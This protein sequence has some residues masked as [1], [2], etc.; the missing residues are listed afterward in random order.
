MSAVRTLAS[1]TAWQVKQNEL[2]QRLRSLKSSQKQ[3]SSRAEALSVSL[4]ETLAQLKASPTLLVPSYQ[5]KRGATHSAQPRLRLAEMSTYLEHSELA[6]ET[7]V[8][9]TSNRSSRGDREPHH[10]TPSMPSSPSPAILP[11]PA[12]RPTLPAAQPV[13]DASFELA[14]CADTP[15][16]S[17]SPR[18]LAAQHVTVS[19]LPAPLSLPTAPM[20]QPVFPR[21]SSS[22]ASRASSAASSDAGSDALL[23]RAHAL[24]RS[25]SDSL[26][27]QIKLAAVDDAVHASMSSLESAGMAVSQ[28]ASRPPRHTQPASSDQQFEQLRWRAASEASMLSSIAAQSEPWEND[29]VRDG[30]PVLSQAPPGESVSVS[31]S[32]PAAAASTAVATATLQH[33][34]VSSHSCHIAPEQLPAASAAGLA[35]SHSYCTVADMQP[36]VPAQASSHQQD[37]ALS[38]SAMSPAE[39]AFISQLSVFDR[40]PSP[41]YASPYTRYAAMQAQRSPCPSPARPPQAFVAVSAQPVPAS[42]MLRTA[43]ALG[44]APPRRTVEQWGQQ[45]DSPVCDVPS[46]PA[47]AL[48]PSS[49]RAQGAGQTSLRDIDWDELAD[50]M[51]ALA[52]SPAPRSSHGI[53]A[54]GLSIATD[55]R[56]FAVAAQLQPAPSKLSP[57]RNSSSRVPERSPTSTG[58][59]AK[60]TAPSS[61]LGPPQRVRTKKKARQPLG[62][63]PAAKSHAKPH[64]RKKKLGGSSRGAG[65][66]GGVPDVSAMSTSA[67]LAWSKA[68]MES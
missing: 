30:I 57:S 67:L 60:H 38:P 42:A 47:R 62:A 2:R 59:S 50:V 58:A 39:A 29:S 5:A 46:E 20:Q 25:V 48:Q 14:A 41:S 15:A 68:A 49:N 64:K 10:S 9:S 27:R 18:G 31:D 6:P 12:S 52:G 61:T 7:A 37:L 3:A 17:S 54:S 33:L 53:E 11:T 26:R 51:S 40:S 44:V 36:T 4:A 66:A 65:V 22:A 24:S 43:A 32:P 63:K 45:A 21:R 34:H 19:A 13:A 35:L 1:Q 8:S 23:S 16:S 56:N 55:P 28:P